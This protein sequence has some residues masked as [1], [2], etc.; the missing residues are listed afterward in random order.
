MDTSLHHAETQQHH[1]LHTHST[2]FL[3]LH[4]LI[5]YSVASIQIY[6]EAS[7][8]WRGQKPI[9]RCG[10]SGSSHI[11]VYTFINTIYLQQTKNE[12]TM[13][14]YSL[15]L[16][17]SQSLQPPAFGSRPRPTACIV[18]PRMRTMEPVDRDTEA[19]NAEKEGSSCY[20]FFSSYRVTSIMPGHPQINISDGAGLLQVG[21]MLYLSVSAN[22]LQHQS[23]KGLNWSKQTNASFS[24]VTTE[25]LCSC[26][27]KAE[28]LSWSKVFNRLDAPVTPKCQTTST[29][30]MK[31]LTK[32]LLCDSSSWIFHT[33][34]EPWS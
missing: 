13:S 23:T 20:Q 12:L 19:Q 9:A 15:P 22:C 3:S 21:W 29:K 28:L 27:T 18:C 26:F 6:S 34:C 24:K 11:L 5:L 14:H 32:L 4:H 10:V 1:L 2:S 31:V 8:R 33:L 30:S 16:P 25:N 17:T 7:K